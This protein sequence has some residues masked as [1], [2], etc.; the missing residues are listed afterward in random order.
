MKMTINSL[1]AFAA[2]FLLSASALAADPTA[3]MADGRTLSAKLIAADAQWQLTFAIGTT[4]KTMPA[5]ELVRW[6]TFAEPAR[7]PVLVLADGACCRPR[8]SRS[9]RNTSPR[10]PICWAR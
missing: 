8:W 7:G 4:Q 9:T 3:V 6:G 5:A 1:S 2:I 10:N